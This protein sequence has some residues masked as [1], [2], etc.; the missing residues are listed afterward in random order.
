MLMV[1]SPSKTQ[2][3]T[4]SLDLPYSLPVNLEQ[5]QI[6]LKTLQTLNPEE[7]SQLMKI[8]PKL[9]DLNYKRYQEFEWPFTPSNAKPALLAFQGDV[10]QGLEI[11]QY[12]QGDFEYAQAHLRIL[13]GF[14]GVLRPLDLIQP[15]RL[16]MHTPLRINDYKSLY[17]FWNSQLVDVLLKDL[18][19][20]GWLIN[21]AS[22]E[23][24]K[25][26]Q[27]PK[28]AHRVLNITFKEQY[29]GT[30]KVIGLHAKRA[31]GLM[32]NFA[33]Q[34][35]ITDPQ[36]LQGFAIAGYRFRADF[37]ETNHWFFC[38]D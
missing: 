17:Q 1:I 19:P 10:Y 14:Y 16:E 34:N 12:A 22:Q 11:E 36:D 18:G 6:L 27:S 31:R 35:Q 30:Y 38:R 26:V 25:A 8:S 7:L 9:A 20:E 32:V 2:N 15:Y 5:T 21:L 4:N 29:K 28:L 3:F 23:Y 13:S 24:F 33:I 37:S